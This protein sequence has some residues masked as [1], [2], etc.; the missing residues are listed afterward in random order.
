ML[1]P[2]SANF[3]ASAPAPEYERTLG[4]ITYNEGPMVAIGPLLYVMG[5]VRESANNQEKRGFIRQ[6]IILGNIRKEACVGE[7][8]KVFYF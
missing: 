2:Q 7:R 1:Q 4:D 3:H 8:N 6:I 5:L